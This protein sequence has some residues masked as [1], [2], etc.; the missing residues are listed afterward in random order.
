MAGF[1]RVSKLLSPSEAKALK[2]GERRMARESMDIDPNLADE[3]AALKKKE[4]SSEL[5][6]RE[7]RRL[8]QLM[9]QRIREGGAEKPE[10]MSRVMKERGLTEKEKKEL[11]ESLGY[12]KGGMVK[13]PAKKMMGGGMAKPK[14]YNKG[15]MANC[16][17]SMKPAQKAK[18]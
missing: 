5:T 11:Q 7:E 18:K 1:G 14:M 6:A 2:A 3:L 17:A 8:D 9:S 16:G 10:G 13:K 15:G 4:K 12:K